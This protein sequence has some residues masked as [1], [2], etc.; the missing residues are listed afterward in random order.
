M[1]TNTPINTPTPGNPS[2]P[3]PP[4][5]RPATILGGF[6]PVT[7]GETHAIA[8]GVAHT[9]AITPEGGVQCWGN[10][11]YGQL[12]DGSYTRSNI[13]V[14]VTG[15]LGATTIVAGG[16]HT[17][18]LAGNDVWCWGLNSKG[19]IGDGTTANRNTPVKVLSDALELTAG[20]DY[21]CATLFSGQ[22]MCWGNNSQ[23]QLADGGQTNQTTPTLAT[24]FSGIS[25]VDAG[26]NKT[27]GLT[28]TGLVRCLT[29]ST[30]QELG[31]LP[32]TNLDVA[33]NRFGSR[34][35]ALINQG[36]PVEFLYDRPK[37]ISQLSGILDVDSG[38]S[39]VCAMQDSGAVY[40]WGFNYYGQLGNNST[41]RS[42]DP[43][44]VTN[45][46]NAW[47]LAVGKYHACTITT[48]NE[49][50]DPGIQCWGLNTDGQLGD[51]TYQTSLVP[52]KVK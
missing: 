50:G 39:H 4:P 27:C 30:S 51:G 43:V 37:L 45:L 44:A 41:T 23:G 22:V 38:Q 2:T 25:N 24:L 14:D 8:A 36:V 3:V 11:N 47:Q 26:R 18:V 12:G 9:C 17:C 10:N 42:A 16:N 7:G 6:I 52:V 1:P 20:Y 19:Q 28:S 21:T 33:V 32:N 31:V 5:T 15:L 35:V 40:C 29:S 13:R 48:T 46:S 49:P 34:I